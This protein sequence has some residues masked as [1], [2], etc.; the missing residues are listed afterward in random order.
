MKHKFKKGNIVQVKDSMLRFW[1]NQHQ[2]VV[3]IRMCL[4]ETNSRD[5]PLYRIVED[6]GRYSEEWFELA[7]QK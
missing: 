6:T 4:N 5:I 3:T 2:T 1:S 7:G